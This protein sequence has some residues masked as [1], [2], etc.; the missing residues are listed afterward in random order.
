LAQARS[1][2]KSL[3]GDSALLFA[4]LPQ[5]SQQRMMRGILS[6]ALVCL[7]TA[8]VAPQCMLDSSDAVAKGLDSA[9][10]IWAA[11]KRCKGAIL[12][13]APVKCEQDLT[14]AIQS[15][16]SLANSIAGMVA[17]CGGI[18]EANLQCGLDADRLVSASAGL[19]AA[20]GTIA[21]DCA[22]VAPAQYDEDILERES[23]LGKCTA[24]AGESMN[25]IFEASNTLQEIKH[26]CQGKS[27]TINSL[28]LVDVLASFGSYIA[29]AVDDCS[30][31]SGDRLHGD[32]NKKADCTSGILGSVAQI[33]KVAKIGLEMKTS[34][35]KS[36][37]RLYSDI[38]SQAGTAI[39]SPLAL[40]LAAIL[41]IAA[42]LS[43][44]AGSRFAKNRQQTRDH[45]LLQVE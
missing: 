43:F 23:Q 20:G 10:F 39:A 36:S 32:G 40:A 45:E 29:A 6:L 13:N 28:D 17:S 3:Y 11:T 25:S 30:A 4:S 14:S 21:D 15:V 26:K 44:V 35:G 34:C 16:T 22:D 18:K 33:S 27:C 41:P 42:V 1:Q 12:A 19:A 38:D 2:L 37:S 5:A 31:Y 7:A 24:D 8:N 9:L